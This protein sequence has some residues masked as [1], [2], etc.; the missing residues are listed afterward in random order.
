MENLSELAFGKDFVER[1]T[2]FN[3]GI[4]EIDRKYDVFFKERESKIFEGKKDRLSNHITTT[5][6]GH[7]VT[8]DL[9]DELPN[10]IKTEVMTLFNSV[11]KTD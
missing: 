2:K 8:L 5:Y 9:S 6:D 4:E 11:W 7:R 10:Y 3:I 1:E